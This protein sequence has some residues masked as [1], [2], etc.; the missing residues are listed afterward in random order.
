M[1][2]GIGNPPFGVLEGGAIRYVVANHCHR[3]VLDVA[4]NQAVELLLT[5][6][7]PN[8]HPNHLVVYVNCFSQKV[9][10][11]SSLE[12][13]ID[14]LNAYLLFAIVGV[15]RKPEDDGGLSYSLVS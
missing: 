8:L 6:S 11:N 9:H 14:H 10:S 12:Y 7:V 13:V 5:S 2:T 4:R 1:L 3:A 15:L